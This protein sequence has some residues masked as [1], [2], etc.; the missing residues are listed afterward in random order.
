MHTRANKQKS[1]QNH[2]VTNSI[3]KGYLPLVTV[4][5]DDISQFYVRLYFGLELVLVMIRIG[6]KL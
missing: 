1:T 5:S 4:T 3:D 2:N 6:T